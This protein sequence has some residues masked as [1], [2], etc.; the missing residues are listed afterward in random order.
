MLEFEVGKVALFEYPVH[1]SFGLPLEYTWRRVLVTDIRDLDYEPLSAIAIE[2]RP[3]VRRGHLLVTGIDKDIVQERKYYTAAMRRC[4]PEAL[5]IVLIDDNE[6][7]DSPEPV[8]RL[9]MPTAEDRFT[10]VETLGLLKDR[11]DLPPSFRFAIQA[12]ETCR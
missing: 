4:Q 3:L 1:N 12:V 10:M 11:C 9:F 2:K 8:S 5:R 7:D 6:P